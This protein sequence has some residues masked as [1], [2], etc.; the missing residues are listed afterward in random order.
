MMLWSDSAAVSALW[1][2]FALVSMVTQWLGKEAL[3]RK[4]E[5]G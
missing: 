3:L 5:A 4:Q 1:M 2:S